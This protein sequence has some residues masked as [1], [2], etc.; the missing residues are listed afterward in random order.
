MSHFELF[1][2]VIRSSSGLVDYNFFVFLDDVVL[3]PFNVA[4]CVVAAAGL[5]T[6]VIHLKYFAKQIFSFLQSSLIKYF[7][8]N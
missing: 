1:V 6:I 7:V 8:V 4:L 2:I 3:E 5:I